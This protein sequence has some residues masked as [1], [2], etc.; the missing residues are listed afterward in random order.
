MKKFC[1]CL[2]A[3]T[4]LF[5][6]KNYS[7]TAPER[8]FQFWND[9]QVS[10]PLIKTKDQ[11]DKVVERLSFFVSGTLRFGQ[12]VSRL[13]DERVGAGFD[14]F[15][16]QYVS[17]TPSYL[18][19][20]GQPF[21][22]R[23]EYEHR[24]RF[25]VNLEK[26]WSTF[27]IRDRNRIE[28]RVRNSRSDS[29]RYRNRIQLRIPVKTKGKEIFVPFVATEPFYDFQAKQWTRNEFSA[30]VSRRL[31]SSAS[32][33]FYYLLQSNRGDAFKTVNIIG[34]SLKFKVD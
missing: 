13:A 31:S 24:L 16:N 27:S 10:F 2:F 5:S 22:N 8:D 33:D 32:S 3:A 19:R 17:L 12:N 7:Q 29:A 6:A 9:V 11:N 18:Y 14:I 26:K 21:A 20:A 34:V 30:G 28:Y 15:V 23:K 4:I 1:F 25:D